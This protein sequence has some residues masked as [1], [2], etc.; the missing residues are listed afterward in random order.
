MKTSS[1]SLLL[2]AFT[3]L[4][5]GSV[6]AFPACDRPGVGSQQVFFHSGF[7]LVQTWTVTDSKPKEILLPNGFHLGVPCYASVD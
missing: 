1:H 6:E 7:D 2:V 5:P 4:L 3:A